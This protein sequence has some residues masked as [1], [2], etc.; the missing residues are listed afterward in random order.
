ETMFSVVV[1]RNVLA[2]PAGQLGGMLAVSGTEENLKSLLA[3][4]GVYQANRN[5][6]KQF[7]LSYSSAAREP[8]LA[9]LRKDRIAHL[10][11]HQ[12]PQP[13]HS[14]LMNDFRDT[15]AVRLSTMAIPVFEPTYPVY[16]GV[17][18]GWIDRTNFK[19]FD[20]VK[21][22]ADQATEPVD[23][24]TQLE[25]VAE[26]GATSYY[27]VGPGRMLETS[28]RSVLRDKV[29][30]YRD[31]DTILKGIGSIKREK[32][33]STEKL[34]K[35][36]W[37]D[38]IKT[39]IKTVAGYKTEDIDIAFS[40]QND[41][42]ID[43]IKKAEILFKIINDEQVSSSSDF[44]VSRFSTIYQ[45]VEYLENYSEASDPLRQTHESVTSLIKG[46]W[47]EVP[48]PKHFMFQQKLGQYD[49]LRLQPS[50]SGA[51]EFF[52]QIQSFAVQAKSR[53]LKPVAALEFTNQTFEPEALLSAFHEGYARM[54][55]R[56]QTLSFDLILID[57]STSE[58][59]RPIG[60]AFKSLRKEA[61]LGRF[62]YL[63]TDRAV[64]DIDLAYEMIANSIRD[65]RYN[66]DKRFMREFSQI[67]VDRRFSRDRANLV[68]A[69]GGSRGIN[70]EVLRRYPVI[71]GDRLV[72]VGRSAAMKPEVSANLEILKK[73]WPSFT[74]TTADALKYEDLNSAIGNAVG[75][76]KIDVL[77]NA[78]GIEVSQSFDEK[79]RDDV[80]NEF[81][82]KWLP[83][84]N[85]ERIKKERAIE[86][87][88]HYSSALTEF[89]NR[90]Q[91]VYAF[92][93]GLI[94]RE[95]AK[96]GSIASGGPGKTSV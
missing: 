78:C 6:L 68:V 15:L 94:E 30:A 52:D 69:V 84:E 51:I 28:I 55:A 20:Y 54:M 44:S 13:Y 83:F 17:L 40:F 64:T 71:P 23:F 4:P 19:K 96:S 76:A 62:L 41:L 16:S 47:R 74:Y 21:L 75:E 88:I 91:V 8:L 38:K 57:H 65:V 37:F 43:S 90:G 27:E 31:T 63:N 79:D 46:D 3:Q 59:F 7:V 29:L 36:K 93:N 35:S 87:L 73:H 86:K 5:S 92:S 53:G 77:F 24:V 25:A 22:L 82:S 11:L 58:K 80:K 14:P 2:P 61:N 67:S 10:I 33:E 81:R 66:G 89:G 18:H 32:A 70:F 9:Q 42:G 48:L 1:Y 56:G 50:L 45:A 85:I 72:L 26:M 34:A 49:I 12:L 39:A 60:A 95:C